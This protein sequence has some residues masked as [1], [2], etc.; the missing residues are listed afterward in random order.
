MKAAKKTNSNA[1]TTSFT[2]SFNQYIEAQP[3][4]QQSYQR[5]TTDHL[6]ASEI[7]TKKKPITTEHNKATIIN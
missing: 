7:N 1:E 6:A 5:A 2:N 4:D 3:K